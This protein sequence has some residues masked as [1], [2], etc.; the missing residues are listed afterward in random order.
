MNTIRRASTFLLATL[1][2]ALAAGCTTAQPA[3]PSPVLTATLP[4]IDE[5]STPSPEI[6][7]PKPPV[8][9]VG[10]DFLALQEQMAAAV[11]TT[12]MP[13]EYAVAVT[14]LQ[15]GETVSVN[16]DV[17]RLSGCVMNLFV[18]LQV[19]RDLEA[20]RYAL[21]EADALVAA[22]TWSSNA[23]TA[24]ELYVLV[25][26]GD[27]TR[28]VERVDALIR[29]V[30]KLDGVRIDHPPLYHAD[31]IGRDYNNWITAEGVNQALAALWRGDILTP[32][33]RDY[34]LAHLAKVKPGL[35]YLTAVVPEGIV[36]HKN[37]FLEADTG[38]V[39]NDSGIVRLQ[40]NGR[41]VAYAVT[42][43]SQEV[44][45]KYGDAVLGQKVS[46]LAYDV[47]AARYP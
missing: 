6:E 3:A 44:P 46:K 41:E 38:F 10:A 27:A 14:D 4:A 23:A 12:S 25:G 35:N 31:S 42:F 9:V 45:V 43:L 47:M 24:R 21:A 7:P 19:A 30:L 13:G 8:I 40:R 20:G 17:P 29:D 11:K 28:G 26:D 37:G 16:G 33:W 2:F 1:T 39:D 32:K 22:T 5:A 18:I 36:S 15:T 34:V